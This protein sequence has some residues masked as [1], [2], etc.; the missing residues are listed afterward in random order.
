MTKYP[1]TKEARSPNVKGSGRLLHPRSPADAFG[2]RA[3]SFLRAWVFR[4]SSFFK[5]ALTGILLLASI[6][7]LF[8]YHAAPLDRYPAATYLLDRHGQPLRVFLGPGDVRCDPIKLDAAG[9]WTW[10]ALVAVEDKRFFQHPGIDPLA[11]IRAVG[12]NLRNRA[13]ISGASTLSTQVIRMTEPRPRTVP[14]KLIEGLRAL[15]LERQRSKPDILT[16]YLN[17]APMGGTLHGVQ[18]ASRAYFGKDATDLSLAEAALLMGLPQSPSRYRPTRH[19]ERAKARRRIV[20]HRMLACGFITKAEHHAADQQPIALAPQHSPFQAPHFCELVAARLPG[21]THRVRTTLDP[22]LQHLAESALAQRRIDLHGSALVI[23]EVRTGA[24]RALV[25]SPDFF[26]RDHA[27]QF[28]A[29]TARR[30][31]GSALK[32]FAYA[33]AFDRGL[34]G[35]ETVLSDTPMVFKDYRP[36]NFDRSFAGDVSARQALVRS[37]NIPALRI[38]QQVGLTSFVDLLRQLGLSTINQPAETYGL[39]VVLGTAEVTLLELTNA[40]AALARGGTWA[41]YR[42]TEHE[43]IAAPRPVL[44]SE[45]AY[46]TADILECRSRLQDVCGHLADVSLPRVAWKT[47]TSSGQRDAWT[48]AFNPDYVVGVWIGALSGP[49][50]PDLTGVHAAAPVAYAVF[51][52][53]YPLGDGPWFEPPDRIGSRAVCADS[54]RLP[55]HACPIAQSALYIRSVTDPG[56]CDR[57]RRAS[58]GVSPPHILSPA[59]DAIYRIASGIPLAQQA[60]PLS[61]RFSEPLHWFVDGVHLR[62]APPQQSVHWPLRPGRHTITCSTSRGQSATVRI[63]VDAPM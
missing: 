12:Q 37:L 44:S 10:K 1:S 28:N 31:P 32:P 33:L 6:W 41:P 14:T 8:P 2:L 30:S 55:T 46:L 50:S 39:S 43:P 3:S 7:H 63:Q 27:G 18:A 13:V 17:R 51:R 16:Q 42:L 9:D 61:A 15:Q 24:V 29:A 58:P 54:G 57:H 45:A 52:G 20:L 38:T 48:I 19:P 34:C 40:Y 21:D 53:L 11:L 25:G 22:D 56:L 35:P 36:A 26:D 49:G 59:P 47:G 5:L 60:I 62:E 4:H 23:L